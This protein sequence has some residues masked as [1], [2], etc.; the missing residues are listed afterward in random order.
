MK[1]KVIQGDITQQKADF[2]VN[3][4]NTLLAKGGGVCG[5][6]HKAAG[7]ELEKACLAVPINKK[8]QRCEPGG[9]WVTEGFNLKAKNV[10]HTVGPKW[11]GGSSGEED[12]LKKCYRG[13]CEEAV[14]AYA[15]RLVFPSIATGKYGCP[16]ETAARI[17]MRVLCRYAAEYPNMEIVMCTFSE[18]DFLIYKKALAEAKVA[19]EFPA[20]W[21]IQIVGTYDGNGSLTRR[22]KVLLVNR[23]VGRV[24]HIAASFYLDNYP[25]FTISMNANGKSYRMG[26]R[27][28]FMY[29]SGGIRLSYGESAQDGVTL[30]PDDRPM[31]VF[32][33]GRES[34]ALTRERLRGIL[35]DA[36]VECWITDPRIIFAAYVV[37][38]EA[39][40][41]FK[42][43]LK[44]L[45]SHGK[46]I[47]LLRRYRLHPHDLTPEHKNT[48]C[49]PYPLM[50]KFMKDMQQ[51]G[52]E[53]LE[54][55]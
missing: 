12:V 28:S 37:L 48:A 16:V 44:A 42:P 41:K 36:K 54:S 43:F 15:K 13:A 11:E 20:E 52:L 34:D 10:I 50:A 53:L 35:G 25:Y 4:T 45:P 19:E 3:P 32:V 22:D 29:Y 21:T 49:D 5:A 30:L 33:N 31:R 24:E 2:I 55:F 18:G 9:R 1:I 23:D 6:I 14:H 8:G 39:P 26:H 40:K 51:K 17:A 38:L 27:H 47:D 46:A 7:P